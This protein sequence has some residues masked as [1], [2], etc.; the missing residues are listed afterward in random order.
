MV[1]D[2]SYRPDNHHTAFAIGVVLNVGFV[3]VEVVFGLLSGS[4]ALLAD[5][6]HNL[7]DVVGLL[8]AWGAHF[9]ATKRPTQTHTYGYQRGTI[10]AALFSGLIILAATSIIAW[11]ALLRLLSPQPVVGLT[12]I[13][14]AAVGVMINTVTALLFVSGQK[15][16]LNLRGAFLHMAAD[17]AVSVG[18]VLAGLGIIFTGWLW[19]DPVISLVIVVVIF[20]STW[21]LVR[22]S[23]RL[24]L[25][26]V[27]THIELAEVDAWLRD[28]EGVE[29]VHDLHIWPVST[30]DT[31]LTAH[32]VM[33][34]GHPPGFLQR[35]SGD[36]GERFGIGHA[37]LQVEGPGDC[38][39]GPAGC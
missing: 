1:H 3:V 23:F 13:I 39:L 18:V 12:V 7:S 33:P 9:M 20:V 8:M 27:P 28:Y 29:D 2:H 24:S 6:G 34:A 25:D 15:E 14:V 17:A 19:L 31:Y 10:L 26:R 16:D 21:G 38:Q 4:M 35:V 30:T 11:E 36:L 32:L 37:T 5:A 22:D